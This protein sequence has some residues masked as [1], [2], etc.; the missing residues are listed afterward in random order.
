MLRNEGERLTRVVVSTPTKE[1]FAVSDT[2]AHNMNELADP[3]TTVRQHEAL[4][5]AMTGA[6]SE[7]I[8]APELDGH[9]NS[10]FT[11]DVSLSTPEGYIKLRMGLD[12]RHGEEAWMAGILEEHG[13]PCVGE[14]RAP[15]TV[16]GGDVTLHGNVALVGHSERTNESGVEQISELLVSMGY[17]VRVTEVQGYLHLG[18]A[19]SAI[20]PERLLV[21][22]GEYASDFLEGFDLV[23]VEK[24][25]PSTGNVICVAPDEIIANPAENAEAMD[26]LDAAGVRVHAVDLSEFRKGAG[27]PTCLILPV[28]RTS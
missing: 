23:E 8:D 4:Q 16:E 27:G 22:R 26:V 12:T 14:I 18:G 3:E 13:E 9:P 5:E 25:G 7:V 11:R 15:G 19:V 2:E 17:R 21:V 24:R 20:A 6:G 1:Y 10:V 28:E